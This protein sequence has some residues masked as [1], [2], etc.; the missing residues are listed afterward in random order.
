MAH[1]LRGYGLAREQAHFKLEQEADVQRHHQRLVKEG[2][3]PEE[4]AKRAAAAAAREQ[5]GRP[6][7]HSEHNYEARHGRAMLAEVLQQQARVDDPHALRR[8]QFERRVKGEPPPL[9]EVE[10]QRA[11]GKLMALG[12]AVG[13][14]PRMSMGRTR[15]EL[16]AAG[17]GGGDAAL[18]TIRQLS[19]E[20]REVAS[21][22]Y[23]AG[24]RALVY[25]T[26][27][28]AVGLAAAGTYAVRS[29]GIASGEELG[30]RVRAGLAPVP[31]GM[32]AWLL[33]LKQRAEAWLGP[34]AAAPVVPGIGGGGGGGAEVEAGAAAAAGGGAGLAGEGGAGG[35]PTSELS[36][37]LQQRFNTRRAAGEGGGGGDA[38]RAVF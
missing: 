33:P 4:E 11:R 21:R 38:G 16:P 27:L 36:R 5:A 37:R 18:A 17:A 2:K 26:L 35:G 28:G 10:L 20:A 29:L 1:I 6:F 31:R 8:K 24:V 15:W 12:A 9:S 34:E 19:P 23:V 30:E 7:E 25:G 22:T 32:R 14:V 13:H 3:L